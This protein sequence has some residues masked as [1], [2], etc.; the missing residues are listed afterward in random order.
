MDDWHSLYSGNELAARGLADQLTRA[1]VRV[2]QRP[3]DGPVMTP[4]G[5]RAH[6]SEVLVPPESLERAQR[7]LEEWHRHQPDRVDGLSRRLLVMAFLSLAP[8]ALWVGLHAVRGPEIPPPTP[9]GAGI[10][11][12]V[13]LVVLTQLEHRRRRTER[14]ELGP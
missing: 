10:L 2:F 8:V 12:I 9:A 6:G 3:L 11:W 7:V 14:I 1:G 13:S 4:T 5:A